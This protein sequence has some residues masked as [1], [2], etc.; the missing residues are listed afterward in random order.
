MCRRDKVKQ[1]EDVWEHDISLVGTMFDEMERYLKNSQRNL[2][3]SA[4]AAY[5][6]LKTIL[7]DRKRLFYWQSTT[8]CYLHEQSGFSVKTDCGLFTLTLDPECLWHQMMY[9]VTSCSLISFLSIVIQNPES[10]T[11]ISRWIRTC[12][13]MLWWFDI[14]QV[15]LLPGKKGKS[16]FKSIIQMTMLLSS[17]LFT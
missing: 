17:P 1:Q 9:E 6:L 5:F 14:L 2:F 13:D 15:I 7:Q 10:E 11:N 16:D 8:I 4:F 3:I 12:L